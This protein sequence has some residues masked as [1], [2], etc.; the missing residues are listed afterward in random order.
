MKNGPSF[1]SPA[2]HITKAIALMVFLM[3]LFTGYRE[4]TLSNALL[5]CTL[6]TPQNIYK[7]GQVPKLK[8]SIKNNGSKAIILLGSLDG[9]EQK[10]RMP[11]CYF[12][13]QKPR[14]DSVAFG[15]CKTLNPLRVKDFVT[16]PPNG[17]FDP[18]QAI[19]QNGFFT[20]FEATQKETFRNPGVYTIQFHYATTS[21]NINAYVGNDYWHRTT[22]TAIQKQLFE[23]VP[24]LELASNIIKITMEE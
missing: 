10:W 3:T 11:Y 5:T 4:K 8:V 17:L 20:A 12:T 22:D 7:I 6:T 16:V 19:D 15:L 23:Q 14:Q 18:F 24:K 2:F 1:S 13:I 9:S 21:G